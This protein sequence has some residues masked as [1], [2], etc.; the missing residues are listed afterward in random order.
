MLV[1]EVGNLRFCSSVLNSIWNRGTEWQ[2]HISISNLDDCGLC[3]ITSEVRINKHLLY[4]LLL[5]ES[6]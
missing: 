4:V 1:N 6:H 3:L 5:L 2:Y